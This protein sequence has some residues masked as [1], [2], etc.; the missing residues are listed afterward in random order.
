MR[1]RIVWLVVLSALVVSARA[2][3]AANP[4]QPGRAGRGN[5]GYGFYETPAY[6][7]GVFV[8]RVRESPHDAEVRRIRAYHSRYRERTHP[9]SIQAAPPSPV[10]YG[11]W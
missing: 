10:D 1:R 11:G 9:R 6:G 8:P 4:Y 2:T 7:Y 5:Q 3:E